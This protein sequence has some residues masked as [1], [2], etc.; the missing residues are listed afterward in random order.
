MR[1][2]APLAALI[3]M[4]TPVTA[5]DLYVSAARGKGK[6]AT[7]E[8]PAKDLGNIASQLKPGDT[9]HIAAGTYLGR[10]ESGAD[11]ID[12]PVSIIGGYSD[13][14]S[15]RDPWGEF[16]TILSGANPSKNYAPEPRLFIDLNKYAFH[17]DGGTAMPKIVVDGIIFDQGPQNHYK[18]EAETLLIRKASPTTGKNPTPDRGALVIS[19]SKTKDPQGKWEIEVRN[20]VVVNSAPTQGALSVNG[21]KNA[22]VTI[23]NNLIVNCTGIGISA[24]SQW[25]GS[26]EADAPKFTITNNTVLF[27]EKYDA[28]VQSFSGISL[29]FDQSAVGTVSNN[30]FA[31]A[32]RYGFQKE[33]PWKVTFKDNILAGNL[34]ADYWETATDAK[35]D[36][37]ALEDE[38]EHLDPSSTGNVAPKLS[39]PVSTEWAKLYAGRAVIDRNA[40]EA[41]VKAQKTRMNEWR[42][43]FGLPLQAD[44]LNVDS[45]IWLP[46]MSVEDAIKVGAQKY[47][48]K[49]GCSKP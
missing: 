31:F 3:L 10:G 17:P 37:D 47:E 13:D 27:T 5:A 9:V 8:A 16:R 22:T 45:P 44:D 29:K 43:V 19:A 40:A 2:L 26:P 34:E 4:A 20:C 12:V 11:S 42:S 24:G 38:A 48:G 46:R 15:R 41:S 30:V 35:I 23:D 6:A 49:Y 1:A 21:Y 39:V 18:D 32:D 14:F 33:G 36:L 7:K 28:F 25:Q